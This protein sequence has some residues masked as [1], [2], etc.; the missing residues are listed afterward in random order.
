MNV[1]V[2]TT[3]MQLQV[4]LP[5]LVGRSPMGWAEVGVVAGAPTKGVRERN[6][7]ET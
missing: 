2:S 1:Q 5:S 6:G 4:Q 7:L 3:R